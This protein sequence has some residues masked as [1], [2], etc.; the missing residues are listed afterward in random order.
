[1]GNAGR[2]SRPIELFAEIGALGPS[3][4]YHVMLPTEI[5]IEHLRSSRGRRSWRTH[6]LDRRGIRSLCCTRRGVLRC[7]FRLRRLSAGAT[8]VWVA[9]PEGVNGPDARYSPADMAQTA[10]ATMYQSRSFAIRAVSIA[11]L[12]VWAQS[13]TLQVRS[14]RSLLRRLPGGVN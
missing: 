2:I 9:D 1:M 8:V 11:R 10:I 4:L 6:Q 14:S 3:T 13:A 5:E 7:A 12:S